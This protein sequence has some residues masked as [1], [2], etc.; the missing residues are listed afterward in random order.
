[1][2]NPV[3][4]YEERVPISVIRLVAQKGRDDQTDPSHLMADVNHW[5]P[6]ELPYSPASISFQS[7]AIPP[8]LLRIE[9]TA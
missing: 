7:I 6:M 1:M 4:E 8:S 9:S 3:N 5:F 2:Y